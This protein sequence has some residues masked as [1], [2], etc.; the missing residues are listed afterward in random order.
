MKHTVMGVVADPIGTVFNGERAWS[1]RASE[2]RCEQPSRIP[3]DVE[4]DRRAVGRVVH[5]E[6]RDG[7][8]IAVAEVDAD[9]F[10]NVAV[11]DEV[12]PVETDWYWSAERHSTPSGEDVV[13]RALSLTRNPARVNAQPLTWYEGGLGER[14]NWRLGF[15]SP[16][17]GLLTRAAE[18]RYARR[19]L[20]PLVIHD[21]RRPAG[22]AYKV[23]DGVWL[24]DDDE[25]VTAHSPAAPYHVRRGSIISVS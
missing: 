19:R 20:E 25:L 21:E 2:V 18:A 9:P 23:R 8:V 7:S 1:T 5:L 6:R 16:E 4:H 22:G 13:F 3:V 11:G 24:T 10:V 12:I 15:G 14:I 17:A